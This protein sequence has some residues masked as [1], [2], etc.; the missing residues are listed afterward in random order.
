MRNIL[1]H[2]LL[3]ALLGA[4][5]F[6]CTDDSLTTSPADRLAY[7]ADTVRFDTL[8]TTVSS[9]TSRL[10]VYNTHK[11]GIALESITLLR[12]GESG[13]RINVDGM[14][15]TRFEGVEILKRDSL[16]IFVEAT[17]DPTGLDEAQRCEDI[18]EF[19][20]NGVVEQV[21]LE[22]YAQDAVMWRGHT[23]GADTTLQA[24]KPF[25]IYDSLW[26]APGATLTLAPGARLCF[27]DKARLLVDGTLRSEGT[28]SN[29]VTLRGDRPDRLFTNLPYDRMPGQ[30][31]G[32]IIR[33]ESFDNLLL[34]THLRGTSYGI[35]I[36]S[37]GCNRLK[38]RIESSILE[39]SNASLLTSTGAR[40]EAANSLFSNGGGP[41]VGICGGNVLFTH[42]TLANYYPF[43]IINDAALSLSNQYVDAD[44]ALNIHPIS[45][46]RAEFRNCIIWG[47]RTTEVT[48][49][50]YQPASDAENL[51]AHRF[52]HCLIRASGEDDDDFISTVW[53][54][55]P[56][57]IFV[58]DDN[59]TYD[60]RLRPDS[61][62]RGTA[63]PE[64]AATLP[65]D[66]SGRPRSAEAPS[67]GAYEASE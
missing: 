63:N 58:D 13:F 30:W 11:Q 25:L 20:Y 4:W 36:D 55:D 23:V 40:I 42:C 14:R 50:D 37:T 35:Q 39:N 60:Y 64:W 46:E 3:L 16:F 15:G 48:L 9:S 31:G 32:V 2:M 57:F 6:A 52:D 26:V 65:Y 59:Y 43:G 17:I 51:F 22:A 47:K 49:Y 33:G 53:D 10:M 21:I 12:G 67:I 62:A 1:L 29:P 45:L 7:S 54:Q 34:H 27:H 61:P 44:N 8:F 5:S 38:L 18:I 28:A 24:G 56:L 41:L 19:R 66:L